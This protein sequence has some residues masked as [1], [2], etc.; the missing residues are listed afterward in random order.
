MVPRLGVRLAH[1]AARLF[2]PEIYSKIEK[3][4]YDD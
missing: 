1:L 4:R 2:D 3:I